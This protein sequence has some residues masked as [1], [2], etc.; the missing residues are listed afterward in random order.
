MDIINIMLRLLRCK[1]VKT[2]HEMYHAM[3]NV[4]ADTNYNILFSFLILAYF[5]FINLI[6]Q[7]CTTHIQ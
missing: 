1:I 5:F 7:V 3:V 6:T 2:P 4:M